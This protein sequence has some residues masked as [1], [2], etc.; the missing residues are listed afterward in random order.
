MNAGSVSQMYRIRVRGNLD[1][2]WSEWLESMSIVSEKL[3]DGSVST[4][5][6]GPLADQAALRGVLTRLWDLNIE[7]LSVSRTTSRGEEA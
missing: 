7:V 5:L 6:S 4:V 2:G 3:T 1:A